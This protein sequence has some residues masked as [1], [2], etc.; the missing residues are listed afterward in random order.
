MV[1][2]SMTTGSSAATRGCLGRGGN[3]LRRDTRIRHPVT[4]TGTY[5]PQCEAGRTIGAFLSQCRLRRKLPDPDAMR[6]KSNSFLALAKAAIRQGQ[7]GAPT[8]APSK[9]PAVAPIA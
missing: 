7:G 3:T 4:P 2:S 1:G 9:P 8:L 6:V 5:H